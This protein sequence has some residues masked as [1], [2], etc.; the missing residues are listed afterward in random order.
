MKHTSN[1]I[2]ATATKNSSQGYTLLELLVSL[3]ILATVSGAVF[4]QINHMQKRSS[5]EAMKLDLSQQAREFMDQTVRDLHMAG[6]PGASMYSDPTVHPSM[7]ASGLV[8]VSPTQIVLEG[9]VNN[10]GTVYSVNISYVANDPNDPT[11]PCI[12]RSAI[13][14]IDADPFSQPT[15]LNYTETSHV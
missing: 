2:G 14:K 12:R 15:T 4:E 10:D 9:D 5:S 1:P 6:Y 7:V 11:C 8:A 3:L 13:A